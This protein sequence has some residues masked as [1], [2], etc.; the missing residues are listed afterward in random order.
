MAVDR[1]ERLKAKFATE[2]WPKVLVLKDKHENEYF[3]ISNAAALW[4][5]ALEILE[6]RLEQQYIRQPE[7]PRP[8]EEVPDDVIEKLPEAMRKKAIS[9][10]QANVGLAK[11]HAIYVDIWNNV[12]KALAEKDGV[13]AYQILSDRKDHEYEGFEFVRLKVP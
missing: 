1:T 6:I 4:R 2:T 10:K 11:R 9:D 3:L 13:L 8:V 12:Q 7:P 5:A